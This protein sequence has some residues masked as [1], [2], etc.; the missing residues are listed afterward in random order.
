MADPLDRV[1]LHFLP[2][3]DLDPGFMLA[4]MHGQCTVAGS[5]Q[6]HCRGD[7]VMQRR[8]LVEIEASV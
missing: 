3:T 5:G 8:V 2:W 7:D 1:G 4:A 6:F